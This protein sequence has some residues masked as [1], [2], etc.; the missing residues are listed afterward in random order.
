MMISG[1][2][3]DALIA[4]LLRHVPADERPGHGPGD[5]CAVVDEG[6]D[7]LRLLKTDAMV[8]GIHFLTD[9]IP[10]RIGRKAIT[11]VL[12]DFAAMGGW[13]ER[14]LV[15]LAMPPETDLA[16]AEGLYQGMGACLRMFDAVMVGGETTRLAAGSAAVISIA[17]E[18]RVNR[19][20]LVLRSGGRAGDLLLV[21]GTLG[22]SIH[23]KHLDFTP[24]LAEAAWLAKHFKPTAMMDLS[25]G[26]ASDLPRLAAASGCG[27]LVDVPALPCTHG[28]QACHALHDGEDYELLFAID[29]TRFVALQREWR[30]RFPH[31]MLS[32][33]GQL[34]Q[35]EARQDIGKGWD[36][37]GT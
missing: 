8:G 24:R 1:M 34:T 31:L 32:R 17:A 30:L 26:L 18:G 15:T 9:E 4:R 33:I 10:E 29:P 2:G 19:Q 36:H 12:S 6:G 16:W 37:F 11:R 25:D 7:V 35:D 20:E 27:F 22:G 13:G 28:S 21:T 14:F 23:G 5:D 3:E